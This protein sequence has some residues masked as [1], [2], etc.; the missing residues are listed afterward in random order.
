MSPEFENW[1]LRWRAV[2]FDENRV[3]A[4][5]NELE[6]LHPKSISEVAIRDE[7]R[8]SLRAELA[9]VVGRKEWLRLQM[10]VDEQHAAECQFSIEEM[11]ELRRPIGAGETERRN[12]EIDAANKEID[13][14]LLRG[15]VTSA[16]G[17]G[18]K[19]V[20]HEPLLVSPIVARVESGRGGPAALK[21]RTI[22]D[23]FA[24]LHWNGEQWKKKLSSELNWVTAC[25]VLHRGRG[26]G[27]RQWNPVLVG[28]YLVR[29]GYIKAKSVR[30]SFQKKEA[31]KP[32]L[33][34]WKTYEADNFPTD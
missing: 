21:T 17:C 6:S 34:D 15:Q 7:K 5:M 8:L 23:S 27:M 31:L 19:T 11:S 3:N 1:R 9:Q 13:E 14:L 25:I 10:G 24:G 30:A 2:S 20:A 26:E 18:V 16:V 12:S 22:A 33:E 32:W 28:A 29:K 4:S